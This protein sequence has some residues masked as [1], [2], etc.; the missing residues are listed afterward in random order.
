V[1]VV[2]IVILSSSGWDSE[3]MLGIE[4][5]CG[6]GRL[7][8]GCWS[9]CCWLAMPW[10][11]GRACACAGVGCWDI[12]RRRS[13][14]VLLSEASMAKIR[15]SLLIVV[16]RRS[17][18]VC[19]VRSFNQCRSNRIE[20]MKRYYTAYEPDGTVSENANSEKNSLGP[21]EQCK[22]KPRVEGGKAIRE[23]QASTVN[24]R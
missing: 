17:K 23:S 9:G 2:C 11:L 18:V 24:T 20:S 6:C 13:S 14:G 10:G 19:W 15:Y 16:S 8:R 22:N 4:V 7:S 21:R 12:K 5:C 3:S 1:R